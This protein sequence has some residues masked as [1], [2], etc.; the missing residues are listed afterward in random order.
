ML[1]FAPDSSLPLSIIPFP[2]PVA[3]VAIVIMI[4]PAVPRRTPIWHA[5]FKRALYA[6]GHDGVTRNFNRST[7]AFATTMMPLRMQ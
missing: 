4:V 7:P 5:H 1:R 2:V 6:E 3:V